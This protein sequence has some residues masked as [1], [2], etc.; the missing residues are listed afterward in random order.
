MYVDIHAHASQPV[1][2][3]IKLRVHECRYTAPHGW[4]GIYI[5]TH[6][7]STLRTYV[8][9][10]GCMCVYVYIYILREFIGHIGHREQHASYRQ[11]S[12]DRDNGALSGIRQ[13]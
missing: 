3:V 2:T 8:Y 13:I 10:H 12:A 11:A 7:G 5:Y 6:V 9:V 4:V 1:Y